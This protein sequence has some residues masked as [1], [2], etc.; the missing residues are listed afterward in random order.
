MRRKWQTGRVYQEGRKK[1]EP[2]LPAV[3]AYVQ[4]WRD[5]PGQA[6]PKRG[7]VSLGV[8]RTRTIAERKAAEKMEELGI[9]SAQTFRESTSNITFKEQGEIWL[10]SISNRKRNPLE[11]TTIDTR[12]YAL[13]KWMYPFFGER[14]LADVTNLAMK[15]FV[16]HISSLAPATIRDYVNIVKAVVAS[17]RD[18]RG[19]PLFMRDWDD[20]FIDVPEVDEQNQ[21]T[22]DRGEMTAILQEAEEPYCTLYALLAGCGPMRA[23]EA[24][25]LDIRSIHEDFRTLEI[26]QK[27]KR[28]VLQDHMKTKNADSRHGRVV[29]LSEPLAAMLRDFVGGRRSGLVFC[30]PDDTQLMQRDILKHSLHPILKKLELEQG[31]FNIFR[32]FRITELETAEVPAALQHTWSGHAKSHASEVYKKLLKRRDWRLRWAE[33][34][35]TGFTLP[36]HQ[37]AAAEVPNG[38][39]GKILEF[40]KVG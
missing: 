32:R 28:G 23:G 29:D 9:N 13:D 14:Y 4:Y 39:S 11:Q 10:Q 35:G 20:E 7:F 19:E 34:A 17:A 27:A 25:G 12:R 37:E 15:E 6:E 3:V 38:K 31:G 30:K 26:V 22:V 40:R 16:D 21:P 24:L 2:W 18:V 33:K 1:D 5:V 8:C 36:S